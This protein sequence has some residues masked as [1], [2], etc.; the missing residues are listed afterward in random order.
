MN[1]KPVLK[2]HRKTTCINRKPVLNGMQFAMFRSCRYRLQ[3]RILTLQHRTL[4]YTQKFLR[5]F[6]DT[7]IN[8]FLSVHYYFSFV[9]LLFIFSFLSQPWSRGNSISIV[10]DCGLDNRAIGV[11]SSAGAEDFPSSLC[12]Q[13]GFE[14]HPASYPIGTG[15]GV[16]SP[17]VKRGRGVTLMTHSI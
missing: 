3:I 1:R 13:I 12:V 14:V 17:G 8:L 5:D 2:S 15:G 11:R 7:F 16:L 6:V 9:F 10:P 4:T